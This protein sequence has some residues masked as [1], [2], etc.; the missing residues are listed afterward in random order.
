[1]LTDDPA[2]VFIGNRII[3]VYS[4][5]PQ[6]FELVNKW[7]MHCKCHSVSSR[8]PTRLIDVGA[9]DGLQEP[10]L[11][12]PRESQSSTGL[13]SLFQ[14]PLNCNR[15]V[16]LSYCWGASSFFTTTTST[17]ETRKDIIPMD[18]L[19]ATIRD[20]IIITRGA[21]VRFLWVDALCILQGTDHEAVND[22]QRESRKMAEIFGGACFTI[23][24]ASASNVGA[25]ILTN[26]SSL[27]YQSV[28]I[29]YPVSTGNS[30]DPS[31]PSNFPSYQGSALL[32]LSQGHTWENDEPLSRR[33]WALQ[34]R[35]LSKRLLMYGTSRL[36]WRCRCAQWR[37]DRRHEQDIDPF[38]SFSFEQ[39][40]E[41]D[42]QAILS[43]W[44]RIVQEYCS[45]DL[46]LSTDK[47]HAIDGLM[48]YY[49]TV[50]D[51]KPVCG[52]WRQS[53]KKDLLWIHLP[54]PNGHAW[55]YPQP[56]YYRAPSWSWASVDGYITFLKRP[57]MAPSISRIE[58]ESKS[59]HFNLRISARICRISSIKCLP[60]AFYDGFPDP[61]CP[62]IYLG[63]SL[64][65]H[66]DNTSVLTKVAENQEGCSWR[67]LKNVWF[68][69]LDATAGLILY[70]KH[71]KNYSRSRRLMSALSPLSMKWLPYIFQRIGVYVYSD[72]TDSSLQLEHYNGIE[73]V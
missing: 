53:I 45:R 25:G 60:K 27:E 50:A 49:S 33:G 5:S 41:S 51:L 42:T 15:Y 52:L 65:T 47:L 4:G 66:L 61:K 22:W 8:L 37:E 70:P 71:K 56:G 62:L 20:A 31:I 35:L 3:D 67:I 55:P 21:N 2:E 7:I 59:D 11:F 68:L 18:K 24:A 38:A 58:F 34:E 9:A 30:E 12:I 39:L 6:V 1:M 19:P 28:K 23:Y 43:K 46:T 32:N 57:D 16:A 63:N 73:I 64:V 17:L 40:D 69:E 26:R 48:Q 29:P 10:K 54:K 14:K 36:S 13:D 44:P 72:K